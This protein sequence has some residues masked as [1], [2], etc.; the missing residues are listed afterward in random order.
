MTGVVG[1]EPR[2][3]ELERAAADDGRGRLHLLQHRRHVDAL[4]G[5][6]VRREPPLCLR[7]LPLAAD[8]VAAPGLV[9]GD[10]DVDEALVEVALPGWRGPPGRLELLVRGEELAAAN[11]LYA[12][13]KVR[14]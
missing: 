6:R 11:E 14:P 5:R 9:P 8:S 2:R 1:S 10:G 4:V 13:L 12:L 3:R 7:E